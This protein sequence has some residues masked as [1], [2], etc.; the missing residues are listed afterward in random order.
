M[1]ERGTRLRVFVVEDSTVLIK[2]IIEW[3]EAD[4]LVEVVGTAA[5]APAAIAQIERLQPDAAIIDVALAAG[6]GFD[7]LRALLRV[8]EPAR[9]TAVMFTNHSSPPY[10]S[11]AMQLGAKHFFDKTSDFV[12]MVEVVR[13]LADS[14]GSRHGSPG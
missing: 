9:P 5:T 1:N 7:V 11:A 14:R 4:P 3:F 8:P 12:R 6:T 10:R 13:T 2:R